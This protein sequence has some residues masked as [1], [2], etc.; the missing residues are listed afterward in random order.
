MYFSSEKF[1]L[2]TCL[3][4][5]HFV[6][7]IKLGKLKKLIKQIL[8]ILHFHKNISVY[9]SLLILILHQ[10]WPFFIP[11]IWFDKKCNKKIYDITFLGKYTG[12]KFKHINVREVHWLKLKKPLSF[13]HVA[14]KIILLTFYSVFNLYFSLRSDYFNNHNIFLLSRKP[15]LT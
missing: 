14:Q 7:C 1:L 13:I 9:S 5:R 10:V 15:F 3:H 4:N 6:R 12:I 8:Q 11:L 2:C